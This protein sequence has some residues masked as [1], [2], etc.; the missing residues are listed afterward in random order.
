MESKSSS[1]DLQILIA[2]LDVLIDLTKELLDT[3]R[4]C[5]RCSILF[6]QAIRSYKR[7]RDMLNEVKK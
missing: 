3:A 2:K 4:T 6:E 7:K 5:D 1:S